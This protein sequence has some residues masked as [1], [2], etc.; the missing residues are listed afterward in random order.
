[1]R[2]DNEVVDWFKSKGPR[3]PDANQPDTEKSDGRGEEAGGGA[4]TMW[5]SPNPGA[6]CCVLPTS[7]KV[8]EK[9]GTLFVGCACVIKSRANPAQAICRFPTR[10]GNACSE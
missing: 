4:V 5:R 2:V 9:W 8:R 7:R 6:A 1:M 3:L 10:A